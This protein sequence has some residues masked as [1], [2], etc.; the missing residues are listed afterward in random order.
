VK[1][2]SATSLKLIQAAKKALKALFKEF[3]ENI[4]AAYIYGSVAW[5]DCVESSDVDV[6]I[7]LKDHVKL[8]DIPH[9]RWS[10]DVKVDI[11]PHPL[12]FYK[13][14]PAQLQNVKVYEKWRKS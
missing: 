10:G 2:N 3:G 9:M 1:N 14:P 13:I 6:H 5:G 12:I 8:K 7:V 11:S 4:V